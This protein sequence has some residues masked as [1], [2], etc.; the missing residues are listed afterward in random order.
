[1]LYSIVVWMRGV[2]KKRM[3]P[4]LKKHCW[5]VPSK[6]QFLFFFFHKILFNFFIYR[7]NSLAQKGE[8]TGDGDSAD[9]SL[10]E[11]DYVY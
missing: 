10:Y 8:Y 6:I 1:M 2:V 7:A 5:N 11:R 3:L 9:K 4:L